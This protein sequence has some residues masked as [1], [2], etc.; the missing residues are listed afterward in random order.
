MDESK[1][2]EIA[3]V[4]GGIPWQTGNDLRT[5]RLDRADGKIVLITD[6]AFVLYE[7]EASLADDIELS[8]TAHPACEGM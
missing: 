2:R 4:T 7:D 5:V 6:E 8:Y 3:A 1:A